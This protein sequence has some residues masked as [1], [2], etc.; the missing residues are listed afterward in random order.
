MAVIRCEKCG[1][2]Y[3][4]EKYRICPNCE[5]SDL[6]DDITVSLGADQITNEMDETVNIELS[7]GQKI[8][9]DLTIGE[10]SPIT[11]TSPVVGWLVC[12]EGPSRGRDYRLSHGWNR[13]GRSA[14]MDIYISD[15]KHISRKHGA[16]VYD[17]R[18]DRFFVVNDTG[19]LT[20]LNGTMVSEPVVLKSGD[21]IQLG[22]CSFVFI[23]YCTEDRKW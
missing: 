16:L 17:D 22:E 15:D 14:E 13:I 9:D 10:H 3:D 7:L 5:R 6:A 23:P 20:Y 4:D 8:S 19:A 11:G 12:T 21:V 2:H 18:S 1:M